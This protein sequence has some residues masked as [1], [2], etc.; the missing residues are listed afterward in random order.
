LLFEP[1]MDQQR[2]VANIGYR[3]I[4]PQNGEAQVMTVI[5]VVSPLVA[6]HPYV[7]GENADAE[8]LEPYGRPSADH[9][10]YSCCRYF[11]GDLLLSLGDVGRASSPDVVA[12]W[13]SLR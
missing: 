4:V 2:I 6:I 7:A 5:T 11:T 12:V 3:L 10:M 9:A 13:S 1:T 8:T